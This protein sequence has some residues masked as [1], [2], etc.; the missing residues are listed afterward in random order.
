MRDFG[1]AIYAR[2]PKNLTNSPKNGPDRSPFHSDC[3][4]MTVWH[5]DQLLRLL[6]SS[7][8]PRVCVISMQNAS[9]SSQVSRARVY[10][11]LTDEALDERCVAPLLGGAVVA[12]LIQSLGDRV[13]DIDDDE[14]EKAVADRRQR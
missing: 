1:V 11:G 13:R 3:S 6:Q 5:L 8:E 4:R 10:H 14:L 12:G 9:G 2:L 7:A